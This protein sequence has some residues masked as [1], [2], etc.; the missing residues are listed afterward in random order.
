MRTRYL[1]DKSGVVES[2]RYAILNERNYEKAAFWAYELYFSGFE[3]ETRDILCDIYNTRFSHHHPKLGI[4]IRRKF[5]TNTAE[6]V[7]TVIKNLTMKNPEV[8]EIPNTKFINVKEYHIAPF[9]TVEPVGCRWKYLRTVCKYAVVSGNNCIEDL[10]KHWLLD[11][12]ASPIWRTRLDRFGGSVKNQS[13]IFESEDSEE[14][15]YDEY[16]FEPDEQPM[17]IQCRLI[18]PNVCDV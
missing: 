10:R 15:F 1:Y 17:E 14:A 4:Y 18:G 3:K 2:L 11:A 8:S 12:A 6:S 16:G 7:A 13:V 5:A 9:Y